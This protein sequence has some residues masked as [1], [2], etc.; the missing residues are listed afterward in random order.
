[1][2]SRTPPRF[3]T[4]TMA[5]TFTAVVGILI[6]VLLVVTLI[7]RNRVRDSVAAHLTT[8]QGMLRTLEQGRMS[9]MQAQ[10][11]MLAIADHKSG[12]GHYHQESRLTGRRPSSCSTQSAASSD[13]LAQ[14]QP[15]SS[16]SSILRHAGRRSRTSAQRLTADAQPWR[17]RHFRVT[18]GVRLAT[19]P[20]VV[21]PIVGYLQLGAARRRLRRLTSSPARGR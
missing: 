18:A 3:V 1:M 10:A 11:D 16:R 19:A 12:D 13:H 8:Q 5:T 15:T 7:V 17:T 2:G 6:S 21:R 9:E 14:R 4:R 20:L